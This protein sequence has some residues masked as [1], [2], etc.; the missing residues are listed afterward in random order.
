MYAVAEY[1]E[2]K[3][4]IKARYS[5]KTR[6]YGH[7][8]VFTTGDKGKYLKQSTT[9]RVFPEIGTLR[10]T[11]T[12]C[13]IKHYRDP[14]QK[15]VTYRVFPELGSLSYTPFH[16][17]ITEIQLKNAQHTVCFLKSVPSATAV[18][19]KVYRKIFQSKKNNLSSKQGSLCT[20][21]MILRKII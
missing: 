20:F 9:Y 5:I 1:I 13:F 12:I 14:V 17:N 19:G 2:L 15:C 21:K 4:N 8:N 11:G 7:V 18:F 16:K 6:L 10:I 3:E